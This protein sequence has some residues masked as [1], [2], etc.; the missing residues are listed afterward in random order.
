MAERPEPAFEAFVAREHDDLLRLAVLLT[1]SGDDA[2]DLARAAL[3]EVR[4][5]WR[6]LGSGGDPAAAARRAVVRRVT[7]RRASDGPRTSGWVA[8][9][10]AGWGAGEHEDLRRALADLPGAVRAAVVLTVWGDRPDA[11]VGEVLRLPL[12]TVRGEVAGA[13]ARLG[14]AQVPQPSSW[15]SVPAFPA[16]PRERLR[17]ELAELAEADLPPPTAAAS[18]AD[19]ARREVSTRRRRRWLAGIAAVCAGAVVAVPTLTG[20][21]PDASPPPAERSREPDVRPPASVDVVDL[22]TRGSL[23]GDAA[24]LD[25]VLALPWENEHTGDY[26]VDITTS[27]ES[28]R[29]LF[30]G[31]VPGGRWAL[32][33]GC[34]DPVDPVDE[35]IGGPSIT[36]E[37]YMAWFA[38]PAGAGPAE[39]AMVSWPYGL[40]PGM[41]PAL[42]D[43]RTGALVVVAEPGDAVEVS[44]GVEIGPDGTGTRVWEPAE[45][46]DG[47]AVVG[48]AAVDLPWNWSVSYRVV[49]NGA[50]I[51]SGVPDAPIVDLGAATPDLGIRY[52]GGTPTERERVA[53][54]QAAVTALA[55]VGVSP[56]DA[57]VTARLLRSTTDPA[58]GTIAVVTAELPGG[59]V[60]ASVQFSQDVPGGGAMAMDCGLDVRP[61][62]TP[63]G[64][65]VLAAAC[66]V[67][68]PRGGELL[69]GL[70]VVTAP[71]SVSAIRAYG[72]ADRFVGEHE[73]S[74][75]VL[76]APIEPGTIEVEAVT[77]AGVQLGRTPVLGHWSPTD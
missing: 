12:E 7:G 77:A 34:P 58:P 63:A 27:P 6:R 46:D 45:T 28:R 52:P 57:R 9:P 5:R 8:D 56:H 31:D 69:D 64:E 40:Y 74:D 10:D 47:V 16:D 20:R 44:Q 19:A 37:P 71:P 75:G 15:W 35:G 17:Q 39:M 13:V 23:A 68:H 43:P 1:G 38:G 41:A 53:A 30:A 14:A 55:T 54:E 18:V 60:V 72:M 21:E 76:L 48:L 59:A 62:G 42:L 11:E 67:L 50:D 61:A 29:V 65:R 22:P 32:V 26:P 33:V 36:D 51:A 66:D 49:R 4:G 73:L 70:L 25:G 2:A 3:T 24:F